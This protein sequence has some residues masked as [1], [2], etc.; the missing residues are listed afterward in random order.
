M[1]FGAGLRIFPWRYL[2]LLEI[3]PNAAS[4]TPKSA[5]EWIALV[6]TGS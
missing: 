5:L 6:Q 3:K 1:A 2:A 4:A